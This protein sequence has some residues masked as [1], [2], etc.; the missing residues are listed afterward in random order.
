VKIVIVTDA[1]KPQ[2]NGVVRTLETTARQLEAMGNTVEFITPGDFR[3]IPCPTYPEIRLAITSW[4][5]VAA[6]IDEIAPNAIHIATEGPLG[7][8]ARHYCLKNKLPFTTA[9]HTR[10]PEYVHAR[11]RLPLALSYSVV[12]HFHAPAARTM[13]A[14]ASLEADLVSRGFKHLVRWGRG[15]D[16]DLFK[17]RP[18]PF[19]NAPR[20]IYLYV[21]R[22]AV[23]KN[24]RDFLDLTLPGSKFVVGDGP[25]MADLQCQYPE[26]H[27][28]GAKFGEE[29]TRY[30]AA[31]DVFVFPSRTDTFGLVLLEALASGV[32]VAAYPVTGPKDVINGAAVGCLDEDL[33]RAARNALKIEP[34]VCRDFAIQHSWQVCTQQFLDNLAPLPN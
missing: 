9:F 15:V 12:R 23:E 16:I 2:V 25:Q 24:I 29:L 30:Y 7:W 21:G 26:V 20:P 6:R 13:V 32:P 18:G 27:F 4:A 5:T 22:V 17:P 3:S 28:V 8:G 34:R 14:T 31:A 19:L 10:F 33:G 11:I 1:W